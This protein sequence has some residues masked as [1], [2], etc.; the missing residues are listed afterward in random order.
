MRQLDGRDFISDTNR[1]NSDWLRDYIHP[2]DQPQ[3]VEAIRDAVRRKGVFE[4]E[5]RVRRVDGSLGWTLSRAVP[6][7]DESGEITEWFGAASDVTERKQTEERLR[8]TQK[9][10]SV[11]LLA[12]GVA[13]DFNNLLTGVIGNAS[14]L[15]EDVGTD[16]AGLLR[17]IINS[18]E[19]AAH[20]TRQ[21]LAYSGKGQVVVRE[22]DVSQ[23]VNETADLVQFSL[24]KSVNLSLN[25]ER[26]LPPVTMDPS[27][28]QQILMNLVING[29]EAI[30]EG[31]PGRITVATSMIDIPKPF[32]DAVGE[33]IQ[34]GRHT[35]IDVTDTGTGIDPDKI[36][37][38]FEPFFST[39]F[40]GRGLGLAA[41]AGILRSQKG[42]I[43]LESTPGK[44]TTF[45]VF[46]PTSRRHTER[47]A[48]SASELT[49]ATVLVVD[50]EGA[51]RDFIGSVLRRKG[52]RVL[53][54]SDG[55]EALAVCEGIDG[56][57]D[58]AIVDIVMPNMAANELLPVL[59]AKLPGIRILLTSG[60]SESE[61]RQLCVAHPNAAFIQKPYTAQELA[62]AV[63]KLLGAPGAT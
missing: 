24:P 36:S 50:D 41:V 35:L 48:E 3:V 31:N 47:L 10:E 21:L 4:L 23:A 54:A 7:L 19:R 27:Q 16:Q 8:Q 55:R 43:T 20:L 37:H 34:P 2:D 58:A 1:P 33:E 12:G 56:G 22:L 26:R 61:A 62:T 25:L 32:I 18:A 46:L 15:L 51:V 14:L 28:L 60:Y 63:G 13:H 11:G 44:G 42:G 53:R 52:Y 6:L 9:L 45:R 38:I 5:H 59:K 17:G 40:T 30:G 57:I 39:K 49:R 29:G